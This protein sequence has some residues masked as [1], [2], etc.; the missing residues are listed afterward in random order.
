MIEDDV[1]AFDAVM[2]AY[3]LPKE[4]DAEKAARAQAIQAALKHATD[5]PLALLP[6]R[7]RGHRSCARS[8]RTRA[9]ST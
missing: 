4:T 7:A 8:H 9:T 1:K 5:V 2:G 3:G 6:R